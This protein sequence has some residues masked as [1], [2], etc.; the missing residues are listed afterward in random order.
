MLTGHIAP[1]ITLCGDHMIST[2]TRRQT[3]LALMLSSSLEAQTIGLAPFTTDGCSRF[4]DGTHLQ[5]ALWQS[6]CVAHDAAYWAGGTAD[7]RKLA[8]QAL[9][10]CVATQGQSSVSALMLMGVRVGGSP[11][12]PSSFR[13]GY[14][15]PLWRGYQPLTDAERA[16]VL[17]RW[18]E[19]VV[20][21][22]YLKA[23]KAQSPIE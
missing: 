22:D 11:F 8:D 13:W 20:P 21:S 12:I 17:A 15:W 18:P 1:Q 3:L 9:Q 10:Q 4:P 5:P 14:G 7:Q 16:E 6:C 23:P 2:K 19:E